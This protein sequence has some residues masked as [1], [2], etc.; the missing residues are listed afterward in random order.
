M[1]LIRGLSPFGPL[2][3]PN[4]RAAGDALGGVLRSLRPDATR[5]ME[6]GFDA[7]KDARAQFAD[8]FRPPAADGPPR[9]R[10]DQ[11]VDALNRLPRPLLAFGTIGLF[12]DAMVAPEGFALRMRGLAQV[13]EPLWWL[14]GAIVSFYF[15]ARELDHARR[16]RW[17]SGRAGAARQG[18]APTWQTP[19][20]G[21]TRDGNPA[22][23]EWRQLRDR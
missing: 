21:G 2:F 16:M 10:F 20:P 22:L 8:E 5:Q 6:L 17:S 14:L 12:V 9:G 15:G 3:G 4:M 13:P 18:S 1:G 7:Q 19:A 23:E 11:L